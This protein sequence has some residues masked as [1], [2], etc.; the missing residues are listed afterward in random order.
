MSSFF[1]SEIVQDELKVINEIQDKITS[2]ILK[3]H[4]MTR[5]EKAE[6]MN[7]LSDL[8][9]KEKILYTRLS[10]SDDP[11]AIRMKE[12]MTQT[13]QIIG[14]GKTTDVLSIF[15]NMKD[16]IDGIKK[17]EGIDS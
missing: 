11:D 8:L 13:S 6:H 15:D 12:Q 1:D 4:K 17:R 14:F 3:F 16:V 9:E 5:S 2:E 7:L 10:L